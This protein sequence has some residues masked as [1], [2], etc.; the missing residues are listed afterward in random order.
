MGGQAGAD[1]VSDA[2]NVHV[3]EAGLRAG[4]QAQ[5]CRAKSPTA[6]PP[7]APR[8]RCAPEPA[9]HAAGS[10][11][12]PG[13]EGAC[14]PRNDASSYDCRHSSQATASSIKGEGQQGCQQHAALRAQRAKEH[15]AAPRA[16]PCTQAP[17]PTRLLCRSAS[18]LHRDSSSASA[19]AACATGCCFLGACRKGSSSSSRALGRCSG[20]AMQQEMKACAAVSAMPS[21]RSCQ[22]VSPCRSMRLPLQQAGAAVRASGQQSLRASCQ[23]GNA[24]AGGCLGE[25]TPLNAQLTLVLAG[26]SPARLDTVMDCTARSGCSPLPLT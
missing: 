24:G 2:Q 22:L 14:P 10:S 1:E 17:S 13:S 20:G 19:L 5:A 8:R 11:S 23:S 25:Q 7:R 21:N 16:T 15:P 3:Q 12:L 18:L 4:K 6:S 9:S 26:S